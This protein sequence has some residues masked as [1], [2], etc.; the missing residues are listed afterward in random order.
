MWRPFIRK[1]EL[2]KIKCICWSFKNVTY[3]ILVN[4]G[5]LESY[6]YL[7]ICHLDKDIDRENYNEIH[8]DKDKDIRKPI[9]THHVSKT[10]AQNKTKN[11]FNGNQI[12]EMT[13]SSTKMCPCMEWHW[14]AT[15]CN[16]SDVSTYSWDIVYG[17]CYR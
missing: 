9:K 10:K 16:T 4:P 14:T 11:D 2:G 8:K 1:T 3:N 6:W 7:L 15:L 12:D 17:F 13:L 5:W